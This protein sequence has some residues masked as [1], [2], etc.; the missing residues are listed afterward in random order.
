MGI[1]EIAKQEMLA[2]ATTPR[3]GIARKSRNTQ[4][5]KTSSM[6]QNTPMAVIL[7][8]FLPI[9]DGCFLGFCTLNNRANKPSVCMCVYGM[10]FLLI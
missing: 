9:K 5:P 3:K 1:G 2:S 6:P 7:C 4:I 8:F 10:G